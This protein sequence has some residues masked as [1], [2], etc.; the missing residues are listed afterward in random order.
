[1]SSKLTTFGIV[2][3][4]TLTSSIALAE[5]APSLGFDISAD[6]VGKYIFRG[7]NLQD[8][9][10]FQPSVNLTYGKFSAN[11]WAS[12]ELSKIN[13]NSGEITEVD[14]SL[15]YSDTLCEGI[16]YSIGVINYV[17]PNT[18]IEDTVE[19]YVGL[20]FD[21]FLSPS[22]TLYNDVDEAN[23][24]YVSV[25]IGHT[26]EKVVGDVPDEVQAAPTIATERLRAPSRLISRIT[27]HLVCG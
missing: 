18:S 2:L 9:G 13:G 7:Q 5:D 16:G 23:G 6:Y 15:D 25:G 1:M 4:A 12:V 27:T 14:Y 3:I 17:F 8:D 21:T 22:I 20:S 10:A 11:I 19:I 24:S 26:F